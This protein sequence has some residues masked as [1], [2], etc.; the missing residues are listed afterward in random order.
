MT[1]SANLDPLKNKHFLRGSVPSLVSKYVYN[2][3]V[4]LDIFLWCNIRKAIIA[5][6]TPLLTL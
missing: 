2:I 1:G 6:Y 4:K 3:K 5:A